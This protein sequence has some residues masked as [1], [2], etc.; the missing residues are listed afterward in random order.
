M[1]FLPREEAIE[2][3]KEVLPT[4]GGPVNRMDLFGVDVFRV[5]CARIVRISDFT[6]FMPKWVESRILDDSRR[7]IGGEGGWVK[8]REVKVFR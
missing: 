8:G 5:F 3:P 6:D 2:E 7:P 1:N 4:P